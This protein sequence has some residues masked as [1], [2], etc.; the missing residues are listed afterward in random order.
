[1]KIKL[2]MGTRTW[3]SFRAPTPITDTKPAH[4]TV[5]TLGLVLD[6]FPSPLFILS[7]FT[8]NVVKQ[9]QKK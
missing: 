5:A 2:S 4:S 6:L 3:L 7:H 9:T 8:Q 1:M